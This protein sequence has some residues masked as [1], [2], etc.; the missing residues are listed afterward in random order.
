MFW[1]FPQAFS[2][3]NTP[4]RGISAAKTDLF[5]GCFLN[6]PPAK[7]ANPGLFLGFDMVIKIHQLEMWNLHW[8]EG[9]WMIITV[10]PVPPPPVHTW[11]HECV[12]LGQWMIITV[13]PVPHPHPFTLLGD[14]PGWS[15]TVGE[16]PGGGAWRFSKGQM[17]IPQGGQIVLENIQG[18]MLGDSPGWPNGVGNSPR[19]HLEIPQGGLIWLENIQ[20]AHLEIPQGG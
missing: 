9:Y 3:S 11:V 5:L 8:H 16:Y 2:G 12:C 18:G 20:G 7:T 10:L 17:E 4:S 19:G 1:G 13:L 6:F 14:Y 15:N